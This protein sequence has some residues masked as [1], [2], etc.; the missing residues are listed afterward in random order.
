[1][2]ELVSVNTHACRQVLSTRQVLNQLPEA[3]VGM[4]QRTRRPQHWRMSRNKP[5]REERGDPQ[6]N[7]RD[8]AHA[9]R[10]QDPHRERI[11]GDNRTGLGS[12]T[13]RPR[14]SMRMPHPTSPGR[15][16][17]RME[18]TV[19]LPRGGHRLQDEGRPGQGCPGNAGPHR[20]GS[21]VEA[22]WEAGLGVRGKGR[23]RNSPREGHPPL[24]DQGTPGGEGEPV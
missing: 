3:P 17:R 22:A 7:S 2:W 10:P 21:P 1:M 15:L 19:P 24:C 5:A 18:E 16:P 4:T 11:A 23:I 8:H 14:G 6:G 12:W 13:Q 20:Q 9:E